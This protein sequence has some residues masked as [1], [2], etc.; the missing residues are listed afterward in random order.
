VQGVGEE[1]PDAKRGIH[2]LDDEELGRDAFGD[3]LLHCGAVADVTWGIG[4]GLMD[5]FRMFGSLLLCGHQ[6]TAGLIMVYQVCPS[7]RLLC[8]TTS[9]AVTEKE[10]IPFRSLTTSLTRYPKESQQQCDE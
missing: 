7:G 9:I 1:D 6:L 10:N 2:E 5:F 8:F 3:D 4:A